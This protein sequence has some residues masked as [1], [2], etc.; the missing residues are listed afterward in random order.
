MDF[1]GQDKPIGMPDPSYEKGLSDQ[2]ADTLTK[3]ALVM[4]AVLGLAIYGAYSALR[5]VSSKRRGK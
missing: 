5:N 2:I 1:V 4:Y 3:G